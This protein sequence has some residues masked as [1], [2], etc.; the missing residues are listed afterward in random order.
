MRATQSWPSGF[1]N[2]G[3]STG[4]YV[5]VCDTTINCLQLIDVAGNQTDA[6]LTLCQILDE[7][8]ARALN[9]EEIEKVFYQMKCDYTSRRMV[10]STF[11]LYVQHSAAANLDWNAFRGFLEACRRMKIDPFKDDV[12]DTILREEQ[13]SKTDRHGNTRTLIIGQHNI[14]RQTSGCRFQKLIE[15]EIQHGVSWVEQESCIVV[16]MGGTATTYHTTKEAL[17][18]DGYAVIKRAIVKHA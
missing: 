7:A 3:V 11:K 6:D 5:L 13:S 15:T 10:K 18:I 8:Q 9:L 17:A 1:Q 14:Y 4:Y 16:R 2:K 12:C